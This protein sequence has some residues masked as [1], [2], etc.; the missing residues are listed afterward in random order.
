MIPCT[1][2][3][4]ELRG[5]DVTRWELDVATLARWSEQPTDPRP[6]SFDQQGRLGED[7]DGT[8]PW[9][10]WIG[11]S[12]LLPDATP[13][14][15]RATL[16]AWVRQHE[17]L[18]SRLTLDDGSIRRRTLP[19]DAVDVTA[20]ALGDHDAEAL[21]ALLVDEFHTRCRPSAAPAFTV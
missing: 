14:S 9:S 17:S 19:A 4:Q 21:R 1:L 13:E 6:A 12:V 8:A 15:V 11:L 5:G 10:A 18:R 20:T 16:A 3:D 7:P 2:A